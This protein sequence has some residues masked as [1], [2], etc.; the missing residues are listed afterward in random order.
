MLTSCR[1][2]RQTVQDLTDV[3]EWE[4]LNRR[5]TDYERVVDSLFHVIMTQEEHHQQREER[6]STYN[7][8]WQYENLTVQDSIYEKEFADGS[9]LREIWHNET[10]TIS[11]R[12]TVY[13][14]HVSYEYLAD[15]YT[16]YELNDHLQQD[17][18]TLLD[19]FSCYRDSVANATHTDVKV[20]EKEEPWIIQ[21]LSVIGAVAVVVLFALAL[22]GKTLK[23]PINKP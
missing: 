13:R 5:V 15:L 18:A 17:Y 16:Q 10:R 23:M 14:E 12:D 7:R 11:L 1:T 19:S 3:S 9:R 21:V 8:L 6:D 2:T 4:Y 20:V 22:F